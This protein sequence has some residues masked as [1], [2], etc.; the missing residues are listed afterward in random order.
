[1]L[2]D[3]RSPLVFL[4]SED[5]KYK[6]C[7]NTSVAVGDL[8]RDARLIFSHKDRD[9]YVTGF[10]RD[11]ISNL[12]TH[13]CCK[14]NFESRTVQVPIGWALLIKRNPESENLE[15]ESKMIEPILNPKPPPPPKRTAVAPNHMKIIHEGWHHR[16]PDVTTEAIK[17]PTI[18]DDY[19]IKMK[20]KNSTPDDTSLRY[21]AAMSELKERIQ[22]E[23]DER[24]NKL[25]PIKS[26][27]STLEDN[28]EILSMEISDDARTTFNSFTKKY[29]VNELLIQVKSSITYFD[30]LIKYKI[31]LATINENN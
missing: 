20:T 1:M 12:V 2:L 21:L 26:I 10:N 17:Q 31:L 27:I 15:N 7:E 14:H 23:I 5:W 6:S 4:A 13:I 8:V 30:L 25:S 29:N 19:V 24:E 11:R 9:M 16:N 22:K 3:F 18:P 28:K